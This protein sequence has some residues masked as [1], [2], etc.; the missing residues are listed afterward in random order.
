M[1][2]VRWNIGRGVKTLWH[3]VADRTRVKNKV[4]V[5][6]SCGK[7]MNEND[8]GFVSDPGAGLRCEECRK[9]E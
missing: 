3:V 1:K 7:R 9:K 5:H 8:C 4:T 2:Y 6:T